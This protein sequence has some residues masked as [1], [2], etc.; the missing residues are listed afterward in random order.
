MKELEIRAYFVDV[1]FLAIGL[2]YKILDG[3]YLQSNT[4]EEKP[5]EKIPVEFDFHVLHIGTHICGNSQN[6]FLIQAKWK[7][8]WRT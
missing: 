6:D 5:N 1:L 7:F 4:S 8:C 3:I 2:H